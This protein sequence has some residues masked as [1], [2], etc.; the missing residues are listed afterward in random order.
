MRFRGEAGLPDIF[1]LNVEDH[2]NLGAPTEGLSISSDRLPVLCRAMLR[3]EYWCRIEGDDFF[4]HFGYDFYM[5]LG[6]S[7]PCE[8]SLDY[9]RSLGL[10][11]ESLISP[12]HSIGG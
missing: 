6:A 12:Y 4:I 1:A 7:S 11:P 10:F 3:E 9:A 5:Y 2:R 8:H